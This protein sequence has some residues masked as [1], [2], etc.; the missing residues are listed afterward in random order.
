RRALASEIAQ[1]CADLGFFYIVNHRVPNA[2]VAGMFAAAGRFFS[3]PLEARMEVALSKA[4]HYRGYVP[5][6]AMAQKPKWSASEDELKGNLYEAFQIHTEFTQDDPDVR[7]GKPLHGANRWP[8]AM[9]ELR[10]VMLAYFELLGRFSEEMLKL[11]ALGLDLPETALHGFFRKPMMQLRMLH[12]P[13]QAPSD[14]GENLGLRPHTD[15][16]AFTVLA[17]DR[18]GGLEILTRSDEWIEVPPLDGSYVINL[19]EM[20]KVWSDGVFLATPHRVVNKYGNERYS[21]PFFMTP[22]FDA[23]IRPVL[24]NPD[25]AEAPSFATS[26]SADE[27]RTCGEILVPLYDRIWPAPS[28]N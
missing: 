11:F 10:E 15:S 25:R 7:S 17:Q 14:P 2:S 8:S 20:M 13:P 5:L 21:I 28:G 22:D 6:K 9:P 4:T 16:G 27:Q 1:A 23:T 18:V 26:V 3:L 19:G 24:A 12:Y